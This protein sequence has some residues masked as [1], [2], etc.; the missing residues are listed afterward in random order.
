MVAKKLPGDL[1]KQLM[2]LEIKGPMAGRNASQSV[3]NRIAKELPFLYG[4]SAD[5]S[6]SDCTMMKDFS[7]IMPTD[8]KGRNLK[9]GIREFGM[10]TIAAGLFQTG[11]II[12]F[13]GTFL[14]FSDYMRN[15]IR[16]AS[17]SHY[18]VIYQFT[19]DS[20][21]L[22]E[23]GPTHQPIE[24]LAAL[25]ALPN[26]HVFRPADNF[27]VKGAWLEMLKYKGP[28]TIIL[29]RQKLPDIA[30]ENNTFEETT[31][32]GA[33]IAKR[34]K[35]NLAFVLLATGS[36]VSLAMEVA[37]ELDAQGKPTRVVSM[38]CWALFEKQT[39]AYIQEVLGPD[40]AKHVS[41]E[42]ACSMGWHKWIGRK[43]IAIAIDR[44]GASAPIDDLAR[45]YGFTKEAIVKRVLSE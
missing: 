3:I 43:G 33:Y 39:P 9:Y 45:V 7:I 14:T 41:I 12:P 44:F 42:A 31:Q 11:F 34:E 10:A 2:D 13:I 40:S 20:I 30:R 1:S 27:E 28:S 18:Q 4:G 22:G 15:A 38:P 35:G 17:L 19:H 25:R 5:L 26:L 23:D 21:F 29:S 24:H 8:F 16:L 32:R 36:E 37:K 6:G